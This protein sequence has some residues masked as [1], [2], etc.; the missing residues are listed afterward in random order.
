MKQPRSQ[1]FLF[2]GNEV[3]H[4]ALIDVTTRPGSFDSDHIPITFTIKSSFNRLKNVA[5]K[6]YNYRKADFDGLRTTQLSCIPW[7]P[8]FRLIGGNS[9][10]ESFQ[11]LLSAAVNQHVPSL[12]S[13]AILDLHGLIMM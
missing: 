4:E 8:V 6:V 13:D 12:N 10:V 5:R 2:P 11:D 7:M 1:G 3:D 9:S